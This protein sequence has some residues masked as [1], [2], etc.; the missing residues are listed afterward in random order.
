MKTR[1]LTSG[2]AVGQDGQQLAVITEASSIPG[3]LTTLQRFGIDLLL[4][5][6]TLIWGGSFL[7]EQYSIR[8]VGPFTTLAMRFS[9]AALVLV[10][11]FYKH[12]RRITRA[13]IVAGSTIG[14]FLFAGYALQTVGLQYTTTSM[15]GFLTALY[16]PLVPVFSLFI[17]RQRLNVGIVVAVLFSFL[18]LILLSASNKFTLSFGPG[19]LLLVGCSFAFALH[20]VAISKF[21][22][23]VDAIN[24]SIVQIT[25]TA[26]L[27]ALTMPLVHEPFALPSLSVWGANL[28]LGI[29]ATAF[30]LLVMN[31]VQQF[32]SGI[33]ATLSYA[34][35]PAWT[36]L[37]GYLVGER[38]GTFAWIGC[39][40]ILF[41]MIMGNIRFDL[42]AKRRKRA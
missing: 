1:N 27:S 11:V 19:E 13:E 21:A 38:L 30:A 28:F 20:I 14:I 32:I 36:G 41:A 2:V 25:L 33:R 9:I 6:V 29:G 4:V 23:R 40:C 31:R 34:L 15:A 39:L 24:L 3:Q 22:P 10:L 16:V 18:G 8:L 26:L 5:L 17:L 7:I 37:F 35:E 42:I 12:F